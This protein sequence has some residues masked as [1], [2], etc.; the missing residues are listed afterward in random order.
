MSLSK[1]IAPHIPVPA[2]GFPRRGFSLIEIM[3]ALVLG[4]LLSVGIVSLF[5]NVG[6]VNQAQSAL[7]L[8]QENGRY[9][10]MR[11]VDDLRSANG[12]YC[13]NSGGAG[14]LASGST[15][16]AYQDTLRAPMVYAKTLSLPDLGAP[17]P[18]TGW[19]ANAPYPLTPRYFLQGYDCPTG[20][21]KPAIPTAASLPAVG[22]NDGQRAAGA[23]VLTVRSLRGQGWSITNQ[24]RNGNYLSSVDISVPADNPLN[25]DAGNRVLLADCSSSRIIA[26]TVTAGT[27]T[28]TFTPAGNFDDATVAAID[29]T[30]D[31][32]LFNFAKDF[33]T[34]T[35]YLGIQN[36]QAVS[37]RKLSTL[38]RRVNGTA[39]AIVEGV[40]RM[41]F[42][43]GVESFTGATYFLTAEQVND[44]TL[45]LQCPPA[46]PGFDVAGAL[47]AG[48]LWRAVKSIEVH[49]LLNTVN[50]L[51]VSAEEEKYSYSPLGTD[52]QTPAATLPSGLP[53][54]RMMRREFRTLVSVRN[55][56]P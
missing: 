9:A 41:D 50:D 33:R 45:G 14:Q 23:D 43:Y 34:V 30:G 40:E 16:Y 35:Y 29:A 22:T 25:F 55:Y 27:G 18:P 11:I 32:R 3:I 26:G 24:T 7:A 5:S 21:C 10:M 54:G 56:I 19:A 49:L 1:R 37:G 17:S 39:E 2:R 42:L 15:A 12:Q 20:T 4:L 6:R 51:G 28:A 52:L 47:D 38:M 53:K 13:S 48:C 36:D 8:L 31:A 46:S 44:N